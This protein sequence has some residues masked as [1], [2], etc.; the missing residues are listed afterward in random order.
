VR[1][2]Q[3]QVDPDLPEHAEY[4]P[5]TNF[6]LKFRPTIACHH[7]PRLGAELGGLKTWCNPHHLA[8][9]NQ[10]S[11]LKFV[12]SLGSGLDF[13]YEN[14]VMGQ[15]PS[16]T[17]VT[18]DCTTISEIT[19][20]GYGIGKGSLLA[21]PI[22]LRGLNDEYTSIFPKP[23]RDK[24]ITYA[25]LLDLL[26]ANYSIPHFDV[27]KSNIEASEYPVF[28]H[29]MQ[30]PELNFRGT[31]QI[32]LELHRMGMEEHGLSFHSLLFAE[33]LLATF[34]SGGFHPVSF[35]RWMDER[36]A[37][38]VV[39]VNQSWWL[40]GELEARRKVWSLDFPEPKL[41]EASYPDPIQLEKNHSRGHLSLL[42]LEL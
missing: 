7:A 36:A 8:S 18:A 17:V 13:Q 11:G 10:G 29:A 41:A 32:H 1:Y 2:G 15:W 21:M 14:F 20:K 26:R 22:C 35:E 24:F 6:W 37:T 34:L 30:A 19:S 39:F 5:E 28:A 38:D 23:D 42:H 3:R 12:L 40:A 4:G 27:V 16:A 33:L 31:A 25:S 9:L